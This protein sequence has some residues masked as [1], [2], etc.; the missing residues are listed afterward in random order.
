MQTLFGWPDGDCTESCVATLLGCDLS[1]VPNLKTECG[2]EVGK[3][4]KNPIEVLDPWLRRQYGLTMVWVDL[5]SV[6]GAGQVL[7]LFGEVHRLMSGP[8]P[9]SPDGVF[10]HMVVAVNGRVVH[11]PHPEGGGLTGKATGHGYLVRVCSK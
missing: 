11:D 7:S 3:I 2:R 5:Q 1:D 4:G 9:R 6:H 8:S 10:E